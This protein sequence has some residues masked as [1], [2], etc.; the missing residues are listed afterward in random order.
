MGIR[1]LRD[2]DHHHLTVGLA[3]NLFVPTTCSTLG[4]PSGL[5]AHLEANGVAVVAD[6]RDHGVVAVRRCT[7]DPATIDEP[8]G[9]GLRMA[10]DDFGTGYSSLSHLRRPPVHEIPRL[11]RGSAPGTLTDQQDEVIVRSTVDLGDN[12]GLLVV[13]EGVESLETW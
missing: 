8:H 4:R 12:L 11:T 2:F 9:V 7:T 3:V 10:V 1:M 13:A 5:R 6:A